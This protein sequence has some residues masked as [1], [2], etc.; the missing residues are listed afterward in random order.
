MIIKS[1]ERTFKSSPELSKYFSCQMEGL[2]V[3]M[4]GGKIELGCLV[5]NK[6]LYLILVWEDFDV[7]AT[8]TA[9][10]EIYFRRS[11]LLEQQGKNGGR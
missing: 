4:L 7:Q 10:H 8:G 2:C 6:M 9:L 3:A 5:P 11:V 1:V